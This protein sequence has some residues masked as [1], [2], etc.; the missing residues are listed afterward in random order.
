[1]TSKKNIYHRRRGAAVKQRRNRR[2]S[3]GRNIE[4]ESEPGA[5]YSEAKKAWCENQYLKR[6]YNAA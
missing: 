6:K 3:G 2:K 4:G 5:I 1:M